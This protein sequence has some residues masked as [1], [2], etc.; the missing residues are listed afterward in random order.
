MLI[1]YSAKPLWQK[2]LPSP[3]PPYLLTIEKA[4]SHKAQPKMD[5]NNHT[6]LRIS[7]AWVVQQRPYNISVAFINRHMQRGAPVPV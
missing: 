6:H 3:S 2:S 4:S 5:I 1:K 7:I